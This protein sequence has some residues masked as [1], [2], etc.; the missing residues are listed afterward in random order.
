MDFYRSREWSSGDVAKC[1]VASSS[2]RDA[3]FVARTKASGDAMSVAA[4]PFACRIVEKA[5]AA[6]PTAA[7]KAATA[8]ATTGGGVP[9][10]GGALLHYTHFVEEAAVTHRRTQQP[11]LPAPTAKAAQQ[12]PAGGPNGA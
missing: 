1:V 8:D 12:A 5:T 6:L 7:V 11:Q 4:A 10:T 9:G 2:A 3:L